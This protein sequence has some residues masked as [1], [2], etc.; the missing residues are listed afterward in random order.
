MDLRAAAG[1]CG[2]VLDLPDAAVAGV[3]GPS[4]VSRFV[5]CDGAQPVYQLSL[6]AG[7]WRLTVTDLGASGS[8]TEL[9]GAARAA[10]KIARQ[11]SGLVV[12]PQD[13]AIAAVVNAAAFTPGIAPGGL[14]SI[15]GAGLAAT[16]ATTVVE[17][18]GV[19]APVLAATPFQ[20]NAQVPAETSA[21]S[22]TVRVR[23]PYGTAAA[24]VDIRPVAPAIFLLPGFRG[25][26]VNHPDYKINSPTAPV[27]RGGVLIVYATGLGAVA[28]QGGYSVV[29]EPVTAVLN[30]Q[31][32]RPSFAGL[33]PG[34]TGLYQVNI[35][36][37]TATPPGLDFKLTLREAGQESNTVLVSVQ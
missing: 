27:A 8:A 25:A 13:A 32:L 36:V 16:G 34:F 1:A 23:S 24:T 7:P 28:P 20:V 3:P 15:F 5:A 10:Y 17:I 22:H 29:T 11:G 14:F 37:P 26:V 18:D 2:R 21:G 33:A 35:P 31:E 6:A 19:A 4:A 9:A 12:S 30:G